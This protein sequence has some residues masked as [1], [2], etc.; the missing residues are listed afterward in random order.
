MLQKS[1]AEDVRVHM[2]SSH[3]AFAREIRERDRIAKSWGAYSRRVK[4]DRA[5]YL[6]RQGKA[7]NMLLV[8]GGSKGFPGHDTPWVEELVQKTAKARIKL[9]DSLSSF[10]EPTSSE[11]AS[12]DRPGRHALTSTPSKKEAEMRRVEEMIRKRKLASLD[13]MD[14]ETTDTNLNIPTQVAKKRKGPDTQDPPAG[15]SALLV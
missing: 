9:S 15:G 8:P 5:D 13:E 3:A 11:D 6:V 12:E 7:M 10:T 4:A 2:E 14:S 1:L